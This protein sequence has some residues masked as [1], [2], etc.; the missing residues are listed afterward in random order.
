ME[1][2]QHWQHILKYREQYGQMENIVNIITHT[3]KEA[4][5]QDQ[6]KF[7]YVPIK[8]CAVLCYKPEGHGFDS[9]LGYWIFQ[10][11]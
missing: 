8:V 4:V 2:N 6:R 5:N 1:K 7:L 10:L 3:K 9:Q 11:T